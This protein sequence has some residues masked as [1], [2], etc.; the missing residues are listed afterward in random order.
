MKKFALATI[1]FSAL[2]Q[3][4][5][6]HKSIDSGRFR[7]TI[8]LSKF[9]DN[10]TPSTFDVA[11]LSDLPRSINLINDMSPVKNQSDRGACSLFS[12]A[13][14]LEATIKKDLKLEVNLSEEF[15]NYS[16]KSQGYFPT[17]EGSSVL[18]NIY[19]VRTSGLLLERDLAYQPTWFSVG[20][21]CEKYKSNDS[22]APASC[23]SHNAPDAEITKKIIKADSINFI[24]IEKNTNDIIR[25]LAEEKRPIT[26]SIVVNFNGWPQTGDIF[27][28]EDLR[29]EC[30]SEKDKCGLHS[31]L[32]TG[33]DLDKGVFFFKN[34]WGTQ[35]GQAGYGT[36]TINTLDRYA[37]SD[38]YSAKLIGE[39]NIPT[40]Y[41]TDYLSLKSFS[42]ETAKGLDNQL[43]INISAEVTGVRGHLIYMSSFLSKKNDGVIEAAD[44]INTHLMELLPEE[45]KTTGQTYARSVK[46]IM[47]SD[48]TMSFTINTPAVLS[49]LPEIEKTLTAATN[50][51]QALLRTTIY[52]HTDDS[53]FK[54]LK[55]IYAPLSK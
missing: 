12:T 37:L 36:M 35:W 42:Y 8:K 3:S 26:V 14:M 45:S 48:D 16:A 53:S 11:K 6:Q 17:D 18:Y 13:A 55:R 30:L 9:N 29:K 7:K 2:L 52:V 22:T 28:N 19:A 20:L 47:A 1:A 51:Q 34:S 24:G 4:C 54:V 50:D 21:P 43:N 46:Y 31:V 23:F 38:F 32:L 41:N 39:L 33:Y 49:F 27:Y 10:V 40:D 15:I 25:Q 44:D 5:G